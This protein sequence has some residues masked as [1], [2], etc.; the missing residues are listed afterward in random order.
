MSR[1]DDLVKESKRISPVDDD[2]SEL[3]KE[4][5]SSLGGPLRT[6]WNNAIE[7]AICVVKRHEK[8][9]L[10]DCAPKTLVVYCTE[11]TSQSMWVSR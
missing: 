11:K 4:L 5:K 9:C 3:V 1:D 7:H 2:E 8:K 10:G 6:T